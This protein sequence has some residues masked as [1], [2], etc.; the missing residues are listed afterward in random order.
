MLLLVF[1]LNAK[2]HAAPAHEIAMGH[3]PGMDQANSDRRTETNS[4]LAGETIVSFTDAG[5]IAYALGVKNV[6]RVFY[7]MQGRRLVNQAV[8][9]LAESAKRLFR[10]RIG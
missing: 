2:I 8:R 6:H 7:I 5:A 9:R 4:M 1:H 3:T 10:S